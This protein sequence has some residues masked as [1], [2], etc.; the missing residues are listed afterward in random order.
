MGWMKRARENRERSLRECKQLCQ[1]HGKEI[2]ELFVSEEGNYGIFPMTIDFLSLVFSNVFPILTVTP[3]NS[4][5]IN[6]NLEQLKDRFFS[7]SDIT[8]IRYEIR[9]TAVIEF[10]AIG[11]S[12]PLVEKGKPVPA[13][14]LALDSENKKELKFKWRRID[15]YGKTIMEKIKSPSGAVSEREGDNQVQV[16]EPDAQTEQLVESENQESPQIES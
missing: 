3:L 8:F 13:Y 14:I 16:E 6:F 9:K 12:L 1:I 7:T 4:L 11:P 10:I 2:E 15:D 5:V